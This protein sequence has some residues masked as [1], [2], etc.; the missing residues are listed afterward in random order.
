M[1][2][3]PAGVRYAY[4]T[5]FLPPGDGTPVR[6]ASTSA[7]SIPRGPLFLKITTIPGG[8]DLRAGHPSAAAV[9]T[10]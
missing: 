7:G 4:D 2:D 9:V 1:D 10:T 5:R 3:A 6:C 8:G